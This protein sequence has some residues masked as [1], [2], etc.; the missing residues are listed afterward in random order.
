MRYLL[1]TYKKKAGGQIDEE[2][3]LT[4]NLKPTDLQICNIIL[5]YKEKKVERCFIDGKVMDTDW[6]TITEYY[7]KVY[8]SLIE[9]LEQVNT[10]QGR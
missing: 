5:D 3:S 7:K 9:N 4:R 8:P 2:V 1:I 6:N 10:K